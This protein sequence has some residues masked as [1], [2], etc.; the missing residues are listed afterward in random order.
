MSGSVLS[1][2]GEI[3]GGFRHER[4]FSVAAEPQLWSTPDR[5]T[6]PRYYIVVLAGDEIPYY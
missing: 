6:A 5:K 4:W 3:E 1:L 2:D